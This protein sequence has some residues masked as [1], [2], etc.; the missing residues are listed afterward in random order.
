[1]KTTVLLRLLAVT[2]IAVG[3]SCLAADPI[4]LLSVR[5]PA[6]A[7]S[8]AANADSGL[9][10]LS[11]DGRFVLFA[12]SADDLLV[13]TNGARINTVFPPALNVFLLDR[14]NASLTLVSINLTGA[15]G[16]NGDSLP[17]GLS[18]NGRY[19]LFE[20]SASDLVAGDTNGAADVFVRDLAA[21]TTIPV[22]VSTNGGLG[23]GASRSAVM[24]PD[25][26][27]VAFVSAA[28]NLV[29]DD[30]N[31]IPDVF[32]RDLQLGTTM[33]VSVGAQPAYGSGSS[34]APEVTP[35]GQYVAFFSTATNLVPGV[36]NHGDI[37][38]RDVMAG[39]TVWASAYA[40]SA[41][42]LPSLSDSLSFG[43]TISADGQFVAYEA[44]AGKYFLQPAPL[45]IGPG[46][47]LILRYNVASGS[48]DTVGTNA[49]VP[50]SATAEAHNPVMTPDGR[51]VAFVANTNGAPTTTTNSTCILVW[52]AQA[53]TSVLASGDLAG[54]VPTNSIC[55]WPAITPNG[56]FVAFMSSATNLVTNSL[57]G[58][59]HLYV[60]DL[61][62]GVTTL[63]DTG[64]NGVG[65][66]V[67]PVMQ[68][69]LSDDGGFVGFEAY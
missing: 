28:D 11:P 1:M 20:S 23:D 18:T 12:S 69:R 37:Y 48:T 30:T 51:F 15:N 32:L 60:R 54:M 5:S 53:G 67:T 65:S 33:L 26:R 2:L 63:V 35:D 10:I 8:A 49:A 34:E 45:S 17:A 27:Y 7:A 16:G 40:H 21:G 57:A 62:A 25:G 13:M 38:V 31:G 36:S 61:Q 58:G 56:Q 39:T 14:T 42:R 52:D 22:S 66:G 68:P 29:P 55:D 44:I 47:G 46:T 24:T 41:L 50:V 9:P 43:P 19:A 59:F 4:Q 3:G 6:V 64:T